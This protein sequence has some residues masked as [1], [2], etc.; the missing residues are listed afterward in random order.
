MGVSRIFQGWSI[1]ASLGLVS[2]G[3]ATDGCHPTSFLSFS[4]PLVGKLRGLEDGS[5]PTG[6][7]GGA[8]VGAWGKA[9]RSRWHGLQ[10]MHKYFL[11]WDFGRCFSALLSLSLLMHK[12]TLQ[13][14]HVWQ[15]L[16]VANA[17]VLLLSAG[18]HG[19]ISARI[20]AQIDWLSKA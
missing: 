16:T 9:A 5:M 19:C 8:T 17:P 20:A 15:G 7:I 2:P 12:N 14:F 3:A 18:A 4:T 1:V 13:H 10:I 6:P 11:Y